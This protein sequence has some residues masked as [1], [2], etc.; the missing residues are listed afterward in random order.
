MKKLFALTVSTMLAA[1]LMVSAAYA[2][3]IGVSMPTKESNQGLLHCRW[4]LY[5]LS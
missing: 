3:K 2:E 5:L 4:I 1:G